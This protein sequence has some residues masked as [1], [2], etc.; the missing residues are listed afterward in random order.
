MSKEDKPA[1]SPVHGLFDAASHLLGP[2]PLGSAVSPGG[3]PFPALAHLPAFSFLGRPPGFPPSALFGSLGALPNPLY[4]HGPNPVT[5]GADWWRSASEQARRLAEGTGL[6]VYAGSL[7]SVLPP[8]FSPLATGL[9]FPHRVGLEHLLRAPVDM[10]HS[11]LL[12]G[13]KHLAETSTG[14]PV[15]SKQSSS[16]SSRSRGTKSSTSTSSSST[17]RSL[18]NGSGPSDGRKR[19]QKSSSSHSSGTPSP[20]IPSSSSTSSSSTYK[21]SL[22]KSESPLALTPTEQPS[23]EQKSSPVHKK[24]SKKVN[25]TENGSHSDLSSSSSSL[26]DDSSGE[27]MS[28]DEFDKKAGA[29]AHQIDG[30]K[31]KLLAD[32]IRQRVQSKP[33]SPQSSSKSHERGRSSKSSHDKERKLREEELRQLEAELQHQQKQLKQLQ[34]QEKEA[35]QNLPEQASSE[36]P[37][38][39]HTSTTGLKLHISKAAIAKH[40]NHRLGEDGPG[41]SKSSQNTSG[42][43]SGGDNSNNSDSES[44]SDNSEEDSGDSDSDSDADASRNEEGPQKARA[45]DG[46]EASPAKRRRIITNENDLRIPLEHGWRRQTTIHTMG[47]RGI[48]GEVLYF[49]P[50]GKKM[51]TIPDVM[52][53][54]DRN[55]IT[56]LS[57]D[58]FTFNT[59]VNVGEFSEMR[60]GHVMPVP[61]VEAEI[62][63]RI[64]MSKGKRARMKE[65]AQKRKEKAQK[66]QELAKHFMEMKLKRKLEQ[67]E[68]HSIEL[69]KKAAENK[70]QKRLDLQRQKELL[71]KSKQLK[72]AERRKQKEQNKVLKQQEKI[73]RQE[74]LRQEREMRAQHILEEREM[75]RQQAVMIREQVMKNLSIE[76]ERRR[77]HLLLVKALEARKKQEEKERVK[78]ERLQEKR[79]FRERKLEQ[80][81]MELEMARE[82]KRPCEDMELRDTREFPEFPRIHGVRLAGAP[83]AD[84][85]MAIEFMHNFGDA[86]GLDK[87]SIPTMKILQN[88]LMN[89]NDEDMEE[90]L[91]LMSHLVRFGLDDPGVPNP[92]EAVTKLNQKITD[93]ELTDS[94]LTEILRIF[95]I[96][97]NGKKTEMSDWLETQPLEALNPT[98]KAAILAFICNELLGSR[99]ISGEVDKNI[100]TINTLRR[101]KWLVEGKLRQLRMIQAKKCRKAGKPLDGSSNQPN[102]E[103]DSTNMSASKQGSDDEEDKDDDEDKDD[104]D[105]DDDSGNDSDTT[106]TTNA[107]GA[108]S[109]EEEDG[110]TIEECEK[111]I[112]KLT[113]QHGLYRNKVFDASHKLRGL[114]LG[115]DRYKR[116]FW[117]LPYAGGLYLEGLESS[118]EIYDDNPEFVGLKK[119]ADMK[120]E[121]DVKK[122]ADVKNEANVKKEARVKEEKME[123]DEVKD[124]QVKDEKEEVVHEKDVSTVIENEEKVVNGE[125]DSL[126]L[127][128]EKD[129]VKH[130]SLIVEELSKVVKENGENE[131]KKEKSNCKIDTNLFLQKADITKLSDILK[132]PKRDSLKN[133]PKEVVN[134]VH[135][136][137]TIPS[138]ISSHSTSLVSSTPITSPCPSS[139]SHKTETKHNFTSIDSLLKKET[140]STTNNTSNNHFLPPNIFPPSPL[141][142]DHHMN[143]YTDILEQKPWFS[144]LP[145]MPC[146]EQSL[147]RTPH[148]SNS[149]SVVSNTSLSFFPLLPFPPSSPG[150]GS[151]QMGQLQNS[152][153]DSSLL[154]NSDTSL[155]NLSSF[156]VPP[157]PCDTPTS[158]SCTG[159]VTMEMLKPVKI[160]PLPI[161]DDKQLNWWRLMDEENVKDILKCLHSRGIREKNLMKNLQKYLEYACSCCGKGNDKVMKFDVKKECNSPGKS[162]AHKEAEAARLKKIE[163][164]RPDDPDHWLHEANLEVEMGVLE[165][166]EALEERIFQASLQV[167]VS[168]RNGWK[169]PAKA[170]ED[171][172]LELVCR[173]VTDLKE[174]Q[175]FPLDV[176][177]ERLL[178]LE[179]N[180]ERRYL[181][182]P[183]IKRNVRWVGTT[184]KYS[185][186]PANLA[187]MSTSTEGHAGDQEDDDQEPTNVEEN[188]PPGLILWRK[189]VAS[190][191]SCAQLMLCLLQLNNSISWEKSIMKVICQICRKD[192]NEAELLLCDGCDKGYHTYCFKPKM[193]NIPDGDWYCYECISKASGAPHC[194]V[195]G[196]KLGK[197]VECDHC[198]RAIHID[199]LDPPLP[200][201]PKKWACPACMVGKKPKRVRKKRPSEGRERKDSESSKAE[202]TEKK[203]KESSS[204]TKDKDLVICGKLLAEMEKHNCGWPFLQPVNVKKFPSYKKYIKHPMDFATMRTKLR[205][206][207]Y[208]SRHEFANDGRIVFENCE[209]YNEDDSEVGQA[210]HTMKKFLEKR[211]RE[212][213]GDDS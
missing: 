22:P 73:R 64:A 57:R 93:I 109:E 130:E 111:K 91:C 46:E 204:P 158:S 171:P 150:F 95:I 187:N 25:M 132:I 23:H 106:N 5:G 101:D 54:L 6:E 209:T 206:N 17:T 131:E 163:V 34:K 138:P 122:E 35:A 164:P 145:R 52:R 112:E 42:S 48:V 18:L 100:E 15:S 40:L 66:Q 24:R 183:L 198:P 151:F 30:L 86:L 173:T 108:V 125:C 110:I 120:V 121:A 3:L 43:E 205:D 82:M 194:I 94:T 107:T 78:V 14:S 50:C 134:N 149:P 159:S 81:R 9:E 19:K 124:E 185:S 126:K 162:K 184:N 75:K 16:S 178:K 200:R 85:L 212:L 33:E 165:E 98:K 191:T 76:R 139:P 169:L 186:L 207:I 37:S 20:A 176:A 36:A 166:V 28:S 56:D 29:L 170:T 172:S 153:L 32:Q 51:K 70:F 27:N 39:C 49:A 58:N 4:A 179:T 90:F 88:A 129:S 47:R 72:A 38:P 83:F 97:R 84:C 92:K 2:P 102:V 89:D 80:R 143:S 21:P 31:K 127:E 45:E 59:K 12:S 180:V 174:H 13:M 199:C 208:K 192:D 144:I 69:A 154:S 65:L 135:T 104:E 141:I 142:K 182:P 8:S 68:A 188:I 146:D 137:L 63:E 11:S 181:K 133:S 148:S 7:G 44:D 105:K 113:K 160:E 161:P 60:H 71:K 201:I 117:I 202:P 103:E 168:V 53:Y 114:T 147:T 115:Q 156:K 96:A 67:Q 203:K 119:K 152:T 136:A 128:L 193:E 99:V 61:L 177:R 157:P 190:T 26:S 74:Q 116:R 167:K 55:S 195:C 118:K 79:I 197:I 62:L 210:G 175:R 87:D 196:K 155:A 1:P 77:Q 213:F 41:T 123:T 211:F 140:D 10:D 189:A